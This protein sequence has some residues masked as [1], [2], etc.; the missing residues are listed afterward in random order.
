MAFGRGLKRTG[1]KQKRD[2]A[3]AIEN[4][5]DIDHIQRND[6]RCRTLDLMS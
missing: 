3:E 6:G 5:I 1:E 4:E 2:V